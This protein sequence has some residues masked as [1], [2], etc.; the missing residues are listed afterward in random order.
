MTAPLSGPPTRGTG[1]ILVT[2]MPRS[3]TTWLARLLATAPGTALTGREPMNP[4]GRQYALAKTLPGWVE[5][6][7][8]TDAQRRVLRRAYRGRNPWVFSRYGRRQWAA[9]LPWTRCVVKDPFAMLSIPTVLAAT[10]ATAVLLYRHPGAALASYRRMGWQPDL[11]ELAPLLTW[12][13]ERMPS[14]DG[15][16]PLPRPGEV[17]E[18]EAM[19]RFWSALYEIALDDVAGAGNVVVASHEDIAGGGPDAARSLFAALGLEWSRGAAE[20]LARESGG[21]DAARQQNL[22]NF[23]RPPGEVAAAWRKHVDA[24]DLAAIESVSEELRARLDQARLRLR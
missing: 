7:T 4:R 13:R 17:G 15:R 3:G 6:T 2:G 24:D 11:E 21:A 10:G 12:H 8:L 22:H 5:L 20:E 1:P 16:A 14:T 9:P 18:A 19:G 23:D